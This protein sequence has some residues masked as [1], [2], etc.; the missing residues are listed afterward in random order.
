M[1]SSF[2]SIRALSVALALTAIAPGV[3]AQQRYFVPRF[4]AMM[5]H[6]TNRELRT[7]QSRIA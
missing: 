3:W 4:E 6:N 2:R 1:S 7:D 5:E